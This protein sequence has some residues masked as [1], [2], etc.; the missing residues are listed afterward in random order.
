MK[1]RLAVHKFASCDGCQLALLN[2]GEDLL[3]LASR[4]DIVHFAEAGPVNPDTEI[5]IALVEGS[6]TTAHD[7]E[8]IVKI[9]KHSLYVITIGACATSGGLQALRNYADVGQWTASIYAQPQFIQTL[10]HSTPI[11]EHIKVDFE[12]WG[13]PVN[14]QQVLA[15]IHDLLAGV[16]PK[17]ETS[18]VCQECKR[19]NYTCVM[20]SQGLPCLGPVTRNGCGALCPGVG[21]ECYGCYGPAE[22]SNTLALA[23][24]FDSLGL[25]AD[26]IVKRFR[27]INSTSEVFAQAANAWTD[28]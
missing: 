21:R 4:I 25:S 10:A 11:R 8:R 7:A 5:D 19:R 9:R 28:K 6:I 14:S 18:K 26:E 1:P 17:E 24:Q 23:E 3:R 12:L 2:A 16:I 15:A 22:N 20:V 13:C 27:S